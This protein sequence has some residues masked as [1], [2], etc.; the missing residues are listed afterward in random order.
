[1]ADLVITASQVKAGAGAVEGT[2]VAGATV[3]AGQ[4]VYEDAADG[5]IKLADCNLSLAAAKAKGVSLHGALAGQ[6]LRYQKGGKFVAGAGAAPAKGTIYV[7]SGT[8]G[9]IAPAADLVSGMHT[10]ILGVG[11]GDGGI[12]L[13]PGGPFASGHAVP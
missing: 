9:G 7:V 11:D 5:K 1:M 8:A 13:V 2:G 3:T 4:S 12:D 10:T 6:P